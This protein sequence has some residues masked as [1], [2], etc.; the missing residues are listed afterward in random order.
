M[1]AVPVFIVKKKKKKKE[2]IKESQQC[3]SNW[4]NILQDTNGDQVV[5]LAQNMVICLLCKKVAKHSQFI[6]YSDCSGTKNQ[7]GIRISNCSVI[8][9]S[10]YNFFHVMRDGQVLGDFP[11]RL[12]VPSEILAQ[13]MGLTHLNQFASQ[14]YP[15]IHFQLCVQTVNL[16]STARDNLSN[17]WAVSLKEHCTCMDRITP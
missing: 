11:E 3:R 9:I 16:V 1:Y 4:K 7:S 13:N 14:N 17:R 2:I 5:W 10:N 15:I 12:N 6:G 8:R